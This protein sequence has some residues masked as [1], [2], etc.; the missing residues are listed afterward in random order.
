MSSVP[1]PFQ[2]NG[3]MV[4]LESKYS[5]T[6]H[7][8][9]YLVF[10]PMKTSHFAALVIILRNSWGNSP[11]TSETI[12]CLIGKWSLGNE[13][14]WCPVTH[15]LS[16]PSDWNY[17]FVFSLSEVRLFVFH[18]NISNHRSMWG[19]DFSKLLPGLNSCSCNSQSSLQPVSVLLVRTLRPIA[20]LHKCF[21][22]CFFFFIVLPPLLFSVL[23]LI[24]LT[25]FPPS[26]LLEFCSFPLPLHSCDTQNIFF[27]PPRNKKKKKKSQLRRKAC[28][29]R[30]KKCKISPVP[31]F[32]QKD[33]SL[34]YERGALPSTCTPVMY[35][36]D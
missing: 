16:S 34:F 22:S 31:Y 30:G 36:S 19:F 4:V 14:C 15:L 3:P 2:N 21:C 5:V 27:F 10:H 11:A 29:G 7:H 33:L 1:A 35:P 32:P 13:I 18:S 26:L 24:T 28:A 20:W 12:F 9:I 17:S 23:L 25:S 8:F 6:I